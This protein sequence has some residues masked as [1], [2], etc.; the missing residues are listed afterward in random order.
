MAKKSLS[1]LPKVP[2][3]LLKGRK[4]ALCDGTTVA[5]TLAIA[6]HSTGSLPVGLAEHREEIGEEV[7]EWFPVARADEPEEPVVAAQWGKLLQIGGSLAVVGFVV[8]V[9][10]F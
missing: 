2:K 5:T 4:M 7:V 6:A 10:V 1:F 9:L 8:V 3:N